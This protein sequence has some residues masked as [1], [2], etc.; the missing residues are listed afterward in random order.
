MKRI[1][2]VDVELLDRKVV[3]GSKL[4]KV[5]FKDVATMSVKDEDLEILQQAE[6]YFS[7]MADFYT[8][9]KRNRDYLR[10]RQW[11]D[12]IPNPDG[13]GYITEEDYIKNQGKV[14]LKQNLMRTIA[15]TLSGQYQGNPKKSMVLAN[16]RSDA[17]VGE[18]LTNTLY[19]AH[20]INHGQHMDAR[21]FDEFQLS[22]LVIS[23]IGYKFIDELERPDVYMENINPR[24]FVFNTDVTDPRL[25]DLRFICE[26]TDSTIED[27]ISSFAKTKQEADKLRELYSNPNSNEMFQ[28]N[29][30]QPDNDDALNFYVTD[31]TNKC[32][33]YEIW[34]KKPVFGLEIHDPIDGSYE[35]S[36]DITPEEIE[37]EN[38]LRVLKA[39]ENGIT[40]VALIEYTQRNSQ[41]WCFKFLTNTGY[42]LLEGESPYQHG[43]HPYSIMAYPMIDGEIWGPLEDIIDQQ[44]YV[45]RIVTQM[46]F[47]ISASAKGVWM[48]PQSTVPDGWTEQQYKDEII[49][50]GGAIIF[51]DD[52][53]R[54]DKYPK[55]MF[56]Q[57]MPA[58]LSELMGVQMKF[59]NDVSGVQPSMQGQPAKSGTPASLYM[60]EAQN[61][62]LSAIDMMNAFGYYV[63]RRDHKM[64]KV[65]IQ[66]YTEK[67]Y[68]HIAGTDYEKEALEYDPSKVDGIDFDLVVSESNNTPIYRTFMDEM[69]YK[70]LEMQAINI[71][72]FLQNTSMPFADKMLESIRDI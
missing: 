25:N 10:G 35:F 64:L 57:A 62:A 34:Y 29:S 13:E 22:G 61:A 71:E 39:M 9:R 48:I 26:I 66:F 53:N 32:R 5:N 58:G 55:Q 49:K 16:K 6:R 45:N 67:R 42:C 2:D 14:P 65:I 23:K 70:L 43:E 19:Y 1:K 37:A 54:P 20:Q 8:R 41:I 33:L 69:L 11:N 47:I 63:K 56:N 31:D 17:K 38:E 12:L 72:Q 30:L 60:Q 21:N 15:K 40:D 24:R 36:S 4:P 59:M 7:D 44:R 46:D 27:I 3:G 51:K 68:L 50:V 28:L 52:P 18:M